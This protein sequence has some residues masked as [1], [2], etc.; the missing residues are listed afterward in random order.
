M[1]VDNLTEKSTINWHLERDEIISSF[2]IF[3]KLY[4]I[5]QTKQNEIDYFAWKI[6]NTKRQKWWRQQSKRNK[7]LNIIFLSHL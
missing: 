2:F 5:F 6:L 1:K 4:K 3:L 7:I